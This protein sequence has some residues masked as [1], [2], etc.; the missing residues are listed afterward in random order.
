MAFQNLYGE[1]KDRLTNS[2]EG[3]E[4]GWRL[5]LPDFNIFHTATDQDSVVLVKEQTNR[6]MEQNGKPRNLPT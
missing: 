5:K 1:A 4:Q 2:I 6:T 3:E